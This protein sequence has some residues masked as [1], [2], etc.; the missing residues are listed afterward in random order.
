MRRMLTFGPV[1]SPTFGSIRKGIGHTAGINVAV[2]LSEDSAIDARVF[3][4]H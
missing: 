3:Q 4:V 1:V 2:A